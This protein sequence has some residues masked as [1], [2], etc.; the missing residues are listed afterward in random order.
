MRRDGVPAWTLTTRSIVRKR[1]ALESTT[2]EAW[3][4]DTPFYWWQHLTGTSGG[5]PRLLGQVG[6]T[7]RLWFMWVEP[8]RDTQDILAAVA[9][10][11]RTWWRW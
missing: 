6:P 7:K 10:L 3:T 4:F 9:F 2:G 5:V 11:H 8:G 1:H